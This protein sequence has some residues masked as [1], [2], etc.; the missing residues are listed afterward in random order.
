MSWLKQDEIPP[1]W[2]EAVTG[3]VSQWELESRRLYGEEPEIQ[4]T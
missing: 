4:E 1:L 3:E 2:R